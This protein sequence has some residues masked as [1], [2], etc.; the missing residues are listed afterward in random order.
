MYSRNVI[1]RLLRSLQRNPV[2]AIN[3]S[4][5]VGKS[6]LLKGLIAD[7]YQASYVSFDDQSVLFAAERDPGAFL[8]QYDGAVAI[9]EVQ[10][11]PDILLAIKHVV[12]SEKSCGRFLL[13]GSANVLSMP[14]LADSL[15]G[16]MI[17]H[18]LWP[19]SQGEIRGRQEG[20]LNW[21]FGDSK[22][23]SVK[24]RVEQGELLD[25]IVRG[26]Y[27]RS[28]LAEDDL[29]RK[30]WLG[31]YI[32]AILQKDVRE[33]AN[34]DRLR[35]LPHILAVLARRVGN[36]LNLADVSRITGLNQVT[37]KRYYTLLRM[38]F[39]VVEVPAWFA[40]KNRGLAKSPKIYLNDT[41]L[42]CYFKNLNRDSF[43]H[44]R[45]LLGAVLENFVVM[46]LKKQLTWSE[47]FLSL[48]HF[49]TKAG[50]EVDMV[51]EGDNKSIVG[52]EVKASTRIK[53]ED[54]F[55]MKKLMEIAGE[56]FL[57]GII[58]YTGSQALSLG[59]N[60]YALP[61]NFLWDI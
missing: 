26:G 46:E 41:A 11:S 35:D 55:G 13:T 47:L 4:R 33:L 56:K 38:V 37:L 39:L 57:K 1:S 31:A 61:I 58:F 42:V 22:I 16:R 8:G 44:D 60:C 12:D 30:E 24:S 10:R 3:G 59:D 34:I 15:A 36:L 32:T 40:N 5:Q 23:P 48:Y 28:V 6:T 2:V 14:K 9:D 45:M 18:T 50:Y 53:E 54:L 21:V 43:V 7:A 49:R 25:I 20:F 17:V 29:D 27:P 52:I 19:L 51:L